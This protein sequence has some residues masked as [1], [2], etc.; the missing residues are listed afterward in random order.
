MDKPRPLHVG[1]CVQHIASGELWE[2]V[3][4]AP[5]IIQPGVI[6][7]EPVWGTPRGEVGPANLRWE[8]FAPTCCPTVCH[9]T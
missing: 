1:L 6:R 2:L 7:T 3:R 9:L 8:K 5:H 4:F